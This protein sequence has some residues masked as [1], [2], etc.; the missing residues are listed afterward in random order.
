M[1]DDD[2]DTALLE[3]AVSLLSICDFQ[4][5]RSLASLAAYAYLFERSGGLY[6]LSE[7][8]ACFV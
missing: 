8:R 6:E 4:P 3:D 7:E 1:D 2:F 5:Y